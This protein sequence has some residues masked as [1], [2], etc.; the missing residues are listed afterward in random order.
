M[1]LPMKYPDGMCMEE[2]EAIGQSML[3]LLKAKL[4]NRNTIISNAECK[5]LV[6]SIK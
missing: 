3:R 4:D 5:K 2:R 1:K 6:G